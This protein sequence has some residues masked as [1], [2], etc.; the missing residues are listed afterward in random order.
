[1]WAG[2]CFGV[3]RG[4]A[5]RLGAAKR[6]ECLARR[7]SAVISDLLS[8]IFIILVFVS[9]GTKV[10]VLKHLVR[11]SLHEVSIQEP[12]LLGRGSTVQLE[13][14]L[15]PFRVDGRELLYQPVEV[16]GVAESKAVD[17]GRLFPALGRKRAPHLSTDERG[18]ARP[19]A[20]DEQAVK[21]LFS[22]HEV[23]GA[24]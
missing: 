8:T 18:D 17:G 9:Q 22:A 7:C 21:Q 3:W 16:G 23:R 20:P 14:P 1:M 13:D 6:S 5:C 10:F 15:L 19:P 12:E 24:G 11:V 4:W 2:W